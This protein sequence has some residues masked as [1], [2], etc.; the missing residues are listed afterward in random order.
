[1]KLTIRSF[2]HQQK[3]FDRRDTVRHV[4]V[5]VDYLQKVLF[6]IGLKH[7]VNT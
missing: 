7:F 3:R 5:I 2:Q 1:M 4:L 6:N